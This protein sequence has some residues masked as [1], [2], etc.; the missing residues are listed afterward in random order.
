MTPNRLVRWTHQ[1][2]EPS[3][4]EACTGKGEWTSKK[5]MKLN[6]KSQQK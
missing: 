6:A 4:R 3:Y 1:K 5:G 2:V